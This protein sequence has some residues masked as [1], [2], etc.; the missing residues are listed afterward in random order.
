ME[1]RVFECASPCLLLL[2]CFRGIASQLPRSSGAAARQLHSKKMA[3][4]YDYIWGIGGNVKIGKT[5]YNGSSQANMLQVTRKVIGVHGGMG[6][7]R[8]RACAAGVG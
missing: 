7:E 6:H 3:S 4:P 8:R 2:L 1:R 5:Y